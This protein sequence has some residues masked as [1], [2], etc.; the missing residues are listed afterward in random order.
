MELNEQ[1][2]EVLWD[3]RAH[4]QWRT[5]EICWGGLTNSVEDI[6]NGDLGAVDPWSGVLEASAISYKKF[7][8]I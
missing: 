7:H 4:T 3:A 1:T 8:F 5:Q 6:E 2:S